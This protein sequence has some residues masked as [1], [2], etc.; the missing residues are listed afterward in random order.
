MDPFD[1]VD[2][3]AVSMHEMFSAYVRA[4]FTEEQALAIVIAGLTAYMS[5]GNHGA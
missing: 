3:A 4:G 5:G 2:G 1:I